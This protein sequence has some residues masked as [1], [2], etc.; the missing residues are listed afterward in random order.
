MENQIALGDEYAWAAVLRRLMS[1]GLDRHEAVH[2]VGSVLAG[3]IWDLMRERNP[4]AEANA[5]YFEK[6]KRLTAES[7]RKLAEVKPPGHRH[8]R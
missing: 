3:H 4:A 7:W 1:E 8:R 5:A 2:A 6:L